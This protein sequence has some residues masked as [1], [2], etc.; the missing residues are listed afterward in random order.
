MKKCFICGREYDET[1]REHAV[2]VFVN[3][4]KSDLTSL[5]KNDGNRR[6]VLALCKYCVKAAVVGI[7]MMNASNVYITEPLEYEDEQD[8]EDEQNVEDEH[9]VETHVLQNEIPAEDFGAVEKSM[10]DW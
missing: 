1:K 7:G 3:G 6:R 2:F 4:K 10:E 8:V 9:D 5:A